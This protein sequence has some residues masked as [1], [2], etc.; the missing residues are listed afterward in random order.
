MLIAAT[1][2]MGAF[3]TAWG[4]AT[5]ATQRL[6]ISNQSV[7]RLNQAQETFVIEDAWFF[8]NATGH[9]ATVTIRNGGVNG[10][11]IST[12]ADNNTIVWNKGA[13]IQNSQVATITFPLSWGAGKLQSLWITTAN[14]SQLKQD[15][16]S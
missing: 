6:N 10:L 9:F 8:S 1:S 11:T 16:S 15:W 14:G 2:M 5:F 3:L 4:N 7:Q 12:I 13:A